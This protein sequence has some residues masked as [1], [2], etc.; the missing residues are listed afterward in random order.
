MR[1]LIGVSLAAVVAASALVCTGCA[2]GRLSSRSAARGQRVT[3]YQARLADRNV[4]STPRISR[5]SSQPTWIDV[6]PRASTISESMGSESTI[7]ERVL[8][9]AAEPEL[10]IDVT[11]VAA[12]PKSVDA[13]ETFDAS[14]TV[15]ATVIEIETD[16]QAA[17]TFVVDASVTASEG[18]DS[19]AGLPMPGALPAIATQQDAGVPPAMAPASVAAVA[20]VRGAKAV[21]AAAASQRKPAQASPTA[22]DLPVSGTPSGCECVGGNCGV[23]PAA[24]GTEACPGGMC[25]IPPPAPA[26]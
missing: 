13:S 10:W 14:E 15:T 18:E 11:P 25:D 8:T 21:E 26:K 22:F 17:N 9:V 19:V 20:V 6:T 4:R 7:T 5:A 12:E 24:G 23:P 2:S 16:T 3:P 1:H